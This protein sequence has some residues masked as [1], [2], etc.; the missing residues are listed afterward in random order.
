MALQTG[1]IDGQENPVNV[2]YAM[3]FNEV[4]KYLSLTEHAYTAMVA[5]MNKRKFDALTAQQ[6]SIVRD[7]ARKAALFQREGL[8]QENAARLA[9]LKEAGLQ[10]IE[11]VDKA[12]F[13]AIVY[14]KVKA[15]FEAEHGSE[16]TD[17][18]LELRR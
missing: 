18:V 17:A 12:P 13:R 11:D 10:V 8:A 16:L 3:R 1:T 14:E 6:Q 7:A 5:V 9:E 15:D 2:I 4:Q